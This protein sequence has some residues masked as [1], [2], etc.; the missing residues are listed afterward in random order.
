MPADIPMNGLSGYWSFNGSAADDS[1]N[2]RDGT[3]IGPTLTLGRQGSIN[4]AYYFDGIDDR[5]YLGNWFDF[6]TFTISMWVKPEIQNNGFAVII[7]NNHWGTQNWVCQATANWQFNKYSF[8]NSNEFSLLTTE[9]SHL[10]LAY[11][12]NQVYVYLN[13]SLISQTTHSL[14]YGRPK[15]LYLG[16]WQ[17]DV[18]RYWK[19]S[20]DDLGIWN[21]ILSESEIL[22]LYK[23]SYCLPPNRI[24][25]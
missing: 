23:G 7:D 13:G 2:G 10:V 25:F 15:S 12:N 11:S 4:K 19:G 16:Y 22:D 9:W 5:I 18:A 21:R 14:I 8:V 3:V 1:N 17:V 6:P 20:I 24:R